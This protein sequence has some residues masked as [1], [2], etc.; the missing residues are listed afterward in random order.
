MLNDRQCNR[1]RP[2]RRSRVWFYDV[3]EAQTH[4]GCNVRLMALIDEFARVGLDIRGCATD[5]QPCPE[6]RD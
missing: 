2:Q 1:L 5:Q 4:D 3:V 6:G